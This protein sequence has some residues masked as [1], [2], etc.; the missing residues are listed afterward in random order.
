MLPVWADDYIVRLRP[1]KKVLRGSETDDWSNP[2]QL[3][4]TGCSV[5]PAGTS[6]SQD[7]RILGITD[8]F[9]CYLPQCADVK[10]GDRIQFGNNIY[11]ITGEPR[12]WKS[13]TGRVSHMLINIE[14]WEG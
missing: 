4:I 10:A 9:T 7:G 8:G 5:Q 14:R 13:P 3:V 1:G 11:T 12:P 2:E 6:L